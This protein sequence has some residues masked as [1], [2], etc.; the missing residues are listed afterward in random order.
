MPRQGTVDSIVFVI[1]DRL[2]TDGVLSEFLSDSCPP[3]AGQSEGLFE[4]NYD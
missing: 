1:K 2:Q 3:A 4:S